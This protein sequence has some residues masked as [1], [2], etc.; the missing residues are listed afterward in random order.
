MTVAEGQ[1]LWSPQP[2]FAARAQVTL[3]MDWLRQHRGRECTDYAALYRWSVDDTEGFWRAIWDYFDIRSDTP[4]EKVLQV[5]EM[6]GAQWFAGTRVNYAEHVLRHEAVAAPGETAIHHQTENRP[7]ARMS[8]QTLG[9]QVRQVA[10]QL[11]ALGIQPGDRVASYLPNVPET[12]VAMLASM[13]VGAVWSSTAPEFGTG[14]VVDRL[15]QIAPKL[16]FVCDGYRFSGRDFDRRREVGQIV[17]SLPSV[18]HVVWLPYLE[19]AR[20]DPPVPGARSWATLLSGPEVSR[21]TF[22]YERV[23]S[24]HP[25]WVMFSSG[26]TGLPKAITHNHVGQLVEHL[27]LTRFHFNL[28][29]GGVMF[30]YSTTGWAMYNLLV[31]AL[32][33][34]AAIVQ[35]DGSPV[36]PDLDFLWSL[37]ANTG[38]TNFGAS[39]TFVQMM[40]KAGLRPGERFDL[41]ALESVLVAGAPST[42]ETFKWFY[43]NVK[44]DLWVTSQ[45]GGTEVGS[46][47]VGAVPI[48]PVHAGEIQCRCLGMDIQA[49]SDDGQPLID[50]VGEMVCVKPFPSMPICFWNDAEG[51]RYHEA[52]FE[53]F[54]GVWRHGDFIKINARGG[55]YIYGR[56]DSTLNRYGVRIG[57]AEV[58]RVVE[59]IDEVADS[60][61]VCCEL[62][63]GRF[64]MPLFLQLKP[65]VE[66]SEALIGRITE[67]LR[68]ECS[69]RHVPDQMIAV[70][71]IPY[72]LTGKKMEVPV[73][74][75]LMGWAP[76]KAAS[77][78]AMMNPDSL[79]WFIDFAARWASQGAPSQ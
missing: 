2:E 3:F 10:T 56:S 17:S 23:D 18:Q 64:F 34:G 44:E 67:K 37:A 25:L 58:Y 54:P 75:L 30:F 39:P 76:E 49:W 52:Y 62:D 8:W 63:G 79:D 14:T 38:A 21:D 47:F 13:A 59:Q 40:E 46:A 19:P 6:F 11:R 48:L 74:K 28:A 15:S 69:P 72:T 24:Q 35:Y 55:C 60:L 33:S 32:L 45:S 5:G 78:D 73:R 70:T 71:R 41:S 66:L 29:P 51:Q 27:K 61:V 50:E 26:T 65:E 77:R 36:H 9:K 7:L 16:M 20:T 68:A 53:H 43:D 22:R 42:P 4:P 12:T 31:S 1:W 57:S